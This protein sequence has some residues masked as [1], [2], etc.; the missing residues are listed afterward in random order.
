MIFLV[1]SSYK[2]ALIHDLEIQIAKM[3]ETSKGWAEAENPIYPQFFINLKQMAL[4]LQ[5]LGKQTPNGIHEIQN[6]YRNE[7]NFTKIYL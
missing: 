7:G 5:P 3:D 1:S 6:G 4:K 2:S